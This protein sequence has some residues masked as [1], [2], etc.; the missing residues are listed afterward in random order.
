MDK[1]LTILERASIAIAAVALTLATLG[2]LVFVPS[3]AAERNALAL[4]KAPSHAVVDVRFVS[5]EPASRV[6]ASNEAAQA[7]VDVKFVAYEPAT[8]VN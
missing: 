1:T 3:D 7:I 4:Q 8:R 6:K 2:A 5:Y